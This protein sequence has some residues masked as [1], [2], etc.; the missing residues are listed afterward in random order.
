MDRLE[1]WLDLVF[2]PFLE[3]AVHESQINVLKEPRFQLNVGLDYGNTGCGVFKLGKYKLER[4]LPKNQHT[5]RKLLN[6]ES[7]ELSKIRHHFSLILSKMSITK[8]VLLN[9]Y[10]SMKKKLEKIRMIFDI[11]NWLWKSNFG[12]FWQL[13]INPKLKTQNS[14]I[15]FWYVDS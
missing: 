15:S 14:I 1:N 12:S 13:A 9:W 8:N 7:G 11:K 5:K 3:E 6:F 4:F 10:L 2:H